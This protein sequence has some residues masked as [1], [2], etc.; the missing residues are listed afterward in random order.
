[1]DWLGSDHVGTR[2]DAHATI[3]E[4]CFLCV[5]SV[6]SGYKRDEFRGW[7]FTV[8]VQLSVGDSHGKFVVEELE[9]SL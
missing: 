7:Q 6:Q 5:G 8:P 9:V 2:T 4:S 1:M 3:V